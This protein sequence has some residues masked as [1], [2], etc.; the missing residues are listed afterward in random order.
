MYARCSFFV[1]PATQDDKG[2]SIIIDQKP[3]FANLPIHLGVYS[4]ALC[5]QDMKLRLAPLSSLFMFTIDVDLLFN[6]SIRY[7][8][9]I[10]VLI[11]TSITV[12]AML[13][14]LIILPQHETQ[15]HFTPSLPVLFCSFSKIFNISDD[16]LVEQA[17]QTKFSDS[18]SGSLTCSFQNVLYRVRPRFGL[19]QHTLFHKSHV[20]KLGI[21]VCFCFVLSLHTL[22]SY[23]SHMYSHRFVCALSTHIERNRR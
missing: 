7:G 23:V 4:L 22:C 15:E 18:V 13:M 1:L 5:Q 20:S 12:I 3:V 16:E 8:L 6:E 9:V 19:Q 10:D 17:V 21:Q 11:K 2:N 14:T